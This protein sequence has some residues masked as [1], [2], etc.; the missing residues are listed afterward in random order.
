MAIMDYRLEFADST[1]VGAAVATTVVGNIIDLGAASTFNDSTRN[2]DYGDGT[3]I[4]LHVRMNAAATGTTNVS[5]IA[6]Y[7]QEA[8]STTAASFANALTLKAATVV[9]T[10]VAGYKVYDA[11][12]PSRSYK[13]YLRLA[14]AVATSSLTAGTVDGFISLDPVT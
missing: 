1:S 3:P 6:F 9:G 10:Y 14:A 13:R 12:L 2:A 8:G 5:T 11:A 4:Y 7:L